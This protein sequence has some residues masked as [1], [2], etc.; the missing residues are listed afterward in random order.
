MT[1]PRRPFSL[2]EEEFRLFPIPAEGGDHLQV[3][4]DF[5]VRQPPGPSGAGLHTG[6]AE[7]ALPPVGRYPILAHR[8]CLL[9]ADLSALPAADAEVI[10]ALQG[11]TQGDPVP[12]GEITWNVKDGYLPERPPF[13]QHF[14]DQ[15]PE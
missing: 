2:R 3:L 7:D 9:G 6:A 4:R 5:R 15:T 14:T 10:P 11:R 12:V 13:L 8:D 1:N